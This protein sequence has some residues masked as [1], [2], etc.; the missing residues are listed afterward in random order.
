[1]K[2]V[3]LRV[4]NLEKKFHISKKQQKLENT[5][6]KVKTAVD[7]VSFEAYRG[8]IFGLLGPNGAGKTTTLRM[9]ATLLKPD[10]GDVLVDGSSILTHPEQVREKIG[11]LTSELKLEEFF[12]PNYLFRFF[13]DLHNIPEEEQ[14]K[15][16]AYL[17]GVF[18]ID[19]FAEVKVANLSTG[20]KQKVS[21]AISLVHDPDIIIFDEPTNGLDVLT[22]KVVTDFL[23]E[24]KKQGKTVIVSTHIFSLIEKICDRVGIVIHGKMVE[25]DSLEAVCQGVSLE[26]RFFDLFQAMEEN[27]GDLSAIINVQGQAGKSTAKDNDEPQQ[28]ETVVN[29]EPA[30]TCAAEKTTDRAI[31]KT[32]A[33]FT[34]LK[35]ELARF[36]GDSRMVFSTILL[37]GLLIFVMYQFMGDAM[38]KQFTPEQADRKC[39]VSN[40][41]EAW[42]DPLKELGFS[43]QD[44]TAD[45]VD[46]ARKQ[47]KDQKKDLVILFPDQFEDQVASY[48]ISSGQKAP[49]IEIYYNSA[50]TDSSDAYETMCA[51]LDQQESLIANKFD[52]NA[53]KQDAKEYDLASEEDTTAKL[54]SSMLPFLL[55][56]FLYSGCVAVAPESIAGEKERGT[57]T[58]LLVT[59]AKRSHIALGKIGALSFIAVLGGASSAIGTV[60][61]MPKLVGGSS[62][63]SGANYQLQDYVLLGVVI[64]STALVLVTLISLISAFAKTVREA[65]TYVTPLMIVVMLLGV[66]SM[67]GDGAKQALGY[68]AIPLY[69]SI[70]SM[71]GILEFH[72]NAVHILMTICSNLVVTAIGVSVLA[73]MFDSEYVMFHK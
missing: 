56:I 17:F 57:I 4:Q 31:S 72:T 2:E 51:F 20:M 64:L 54:F 47:V 27:G 61:S 73:K 43:L 70:Q 44:V 10:A 67:F 59:P 40:L 14:E 35:K 19:E 34:I 69:N 48:D 16:K 62:K 28:E 52:I 32:K 8:E 6:D 24:L 49:D 63:I 58:S 5:K 71:I 55:I 65:G 22:A 7:G 68:Y 60:L 66:T 30:E 1:M 26:D 11:F 41:P 12:T 36:F 25:C 37:P 13:S 42:H 29:A 39:Y 33:L 53:G 15:R 3:I 18:G 50:S 21:L 9:I 23:Q 45:E 38:T 46:S